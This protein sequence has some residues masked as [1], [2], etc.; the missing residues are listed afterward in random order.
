MTRK[1]GD[2]AKHTFDMAIARA[3]YI[4]TLYMGLTDHRKRSARK[5]WSDRFKKLMHWPKSHEIERIDSKDAVLIL[6]D[7]SKLR[8]QHFSV[9]ALGDLL[10]AS[11]VMAVSAMDA[12][13]H[14]KI[15][16]YV[17]VHSK[18]KKPSRRLLNEKIKVSDFINGQKK[19]RSYAALRAAIERNLSYQSLQGPDKIADALGLIGVSDFWKLVA[20]NLNEQKNSL[21]N[22]IN[23]VVKRRNQIAHEG[24]LSQS[25]K[26][27]NKS[28]SID[29]KT[30]REAIDLIEK[31]VDAAE[32]II[33]RSVRNR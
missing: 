28:R 7:N 25:K 5:D 30:V 22:K 2:S 6:R 31:I 3:R 9:D 27:R 33:E 17:V 23:R 19:K 10:R 4:L 26:T 14:A 24:D 29:P 1:R 32:K 12:Y 8:R 11:L 13:F 21:Q 16:R 20:E 18:S 15:L